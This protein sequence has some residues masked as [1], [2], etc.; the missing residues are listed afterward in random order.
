MTRL[1]FAA[2]LAPN[3]QPV[4]GFIVQALGVRLGIETELTVG[5][6]FDEFARGEADAGFLCGLPYVQLLRQTPGLLAPLAAPV[7]QGARFGGRP[8]YFSDVVVRRDAP[9]HSFADLRGRSWA[10]NDPDS[11]SGYNVVRA[12]LVRRG[13][14]NGFFS[15]VVQSGYHQRSLEMVAAGDVD[16]ATIDCQVLAI[17]QRERPELAGQVKVIDSLGP[18][19]VQPIVMAGRLPASLKQEARAAL[20]EL[21]ADPRAREV[22]AFGFIERLA[23]VADRDYDDIRHMLADCEQANFM[24]V[25]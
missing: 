25:R 6:S 23:P 5:Q 11:H 19:T 3:M 20:L 21:H 8:I 2:F 1:R 24:I 4:Y 13:E 7:L 18:S 16:G 12:T 22:L 17:E 15:R 10:Y 14:T 9:F